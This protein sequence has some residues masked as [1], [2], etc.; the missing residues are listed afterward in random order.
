[1]MSQT[2][3]LLLKNISQHVDYVSAFSDVLFFYFSL[4]LSAVVMSVAAP[5]LIQ[6]FHL[7]V[8]CLTLYKVVG[9][10]NRWMNERKKNT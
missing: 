2:D 1:M 8:S 7:S 6:W 9:L 4:V 3:S 5:N 10:K